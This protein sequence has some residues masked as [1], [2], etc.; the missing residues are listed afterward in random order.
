MVLLG[1]SAEDEDFVAVVGG[2]GACGAARAR[3]RRS[4]DGGG[5]RVCGVFSHG[6]CDLCSAGDVS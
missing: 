4:H 2:S 1:R 5:G 6:A 3:N